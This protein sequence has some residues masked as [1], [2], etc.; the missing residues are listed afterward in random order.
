MVNIKI[1]GKKILFFFIAFFTVMLLLLFWKFQLKRKLNSKE[2]KNSLTNF[3][4]LSNSFKNENILTKNSSE[5]KESLLYQKD[6][7]INISDV[8][9]SSD[10]IISKGNHSNIKTNLNVSEN[11]VKENTTTIDIIY[12]ENSLEEFKDKNKDYNL[13]ISRKRYYENDYPTS[14]IKND[15]EVISSEE[16][17]KVISKSEKVSNIKKREKQ[18]KAIRKIKQESKEKMKSVMLEAFDSLKIIKENSNLE[19]LNKI[20][21]DN[22]IEKEYINIRNAVKFFQQRIND[23]SIKAYNNISLKFGFPI[24][25]QNNTSTDLISGQFFSNIINSLKSLNLSND[26]ENKLKEMIENEEKMISK[27]WE[28]QNNTLIENITNIREEALKSIKNI[29][30]RAFNEINKL[31]EL[32]SNENVNKLEISDLNNVLLNAS[33]LV[34]F[35]NK[36]SLSSTEQVNS[37]I[38]EKQIFNTTTDKQNFD[39]SSFS[40]IISSKNK[41]DEISY[42]YFS[43]GFKYLICFTFIISITLLLWTFFNFKPKKVFKSK[44]YDDINEEYL[45]NQIT[46]N[47]LI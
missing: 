32:K 13:R 14:N 40:E 42:S 3:S 35:Q 4:N 19:G 34:D 21:I 9:T 5:N 44:K 47:L 46:Y 26:Q 39:S 30:K 10:H 18:A 2:N 27:Q 16:K 17:T 22:Y 43:S 37:S 6:I 20:N 38:I 29:E 33:Q 12:D 23:E 45:N 41:T 31:S 15:L 36:S 24:K 7:P 28:R 1:I 25:I 8:N 11:L